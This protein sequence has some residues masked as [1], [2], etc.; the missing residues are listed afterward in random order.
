MRP[1]SDPASA[2]DLTN[3][4]WR[5]LSGEHAHLAHGTRAALRY[6]PEV[7]PFGALEQ[8]SRACVEN[9]AQ[10]MQ[11]GEEVCL[12]GQQADVPEL[13]EV[14]SRSEAVQMVY[15]ATSSPP[16]SSA[17]IRRLE[18]ADLPSMEALIAAVFPGYFRRRTPE[19]GKYY[20]IF[21]AGQL[22]AMAGERFVP[23]GL[24]EVSAICTHTAHQGKGL[25]AQLTQ[26]LVGNILLGGRRPFLHVGSHNAK[27]MRLYSRLGFAATAVVTTNFYRRK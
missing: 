17:G 25:A 21:I 18:P 6:Q 7:A 27:A 22:A 11:P 1:E 10:L 13:F 12:V 8:Q 19:M 5:S 24:R 26:F 23:P 3:L 20:G 4:V 16:V 2:C 9:L 15:D 14:I